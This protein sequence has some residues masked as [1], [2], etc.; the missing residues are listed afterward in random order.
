MKGK[1]ERK[2]V[3]LPAELYSKIEERVKTT[4][5]GS[6]EEYIIFILEEVL[7]EDE[8]EQTFSKEDEEEV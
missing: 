2:T 5:F 7:K 1:E 6:V 4:E 3:S 8:E